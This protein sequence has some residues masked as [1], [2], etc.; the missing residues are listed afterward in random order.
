MDV[1]FKCNT[2]SLVKIMNLLNGEF[3][4][5]LKRTDVFSLGKVI[6]RTSSPI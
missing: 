4:E 5:I 2:G 3:L 1:N 6:L